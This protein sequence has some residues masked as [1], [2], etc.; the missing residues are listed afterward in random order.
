MII[1]DLVTNQFEGKCLGGTG[2]VNLEIHL[3][4]RVSL[5]S[6]QSRNDQHIMER[7]RKLNPGV[8]GCRLGNGNAIWEFILQG[9]SYST[10]IT[11]T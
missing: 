11:V 4:R 2:R 9:C 10:R 8:A 7:C 1:F 5:N 6:T 3:Y